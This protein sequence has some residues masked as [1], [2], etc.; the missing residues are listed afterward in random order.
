[1]LSAAARFAGGVAAVLLLLRELRAA[2]ADLLEEYAR[3]AG[4]YDVW[5]SKYYDYDKE[6]EGH[7]RYHPA[8]LPRRAQLQP[9]S[10]MASESENNVQAQATWTSIIHHSDWLK[11]GMV[12]SG[13]GVPRRELVRFVAVS[14]HGAGLLTNKLPKIVIP[15]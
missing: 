3:V 11:M 14:Q 13:S 9:L 7:T 6:G 1:M 8:G 5:D 15:C 12:L 4:T 2:H 10:E